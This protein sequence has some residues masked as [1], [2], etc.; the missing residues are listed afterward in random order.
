MG[1]GNGIARQPVLVRMP[2]AL[3]EIS[4]IYQN[5]RC[6]PTFSATIVEL[7]ETHPALA[8]LVTAVY[9]QAQEGPTPLGS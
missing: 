2:T 4:K 5:K 1:G 3:V 9:S 7:L 8:E 6:L